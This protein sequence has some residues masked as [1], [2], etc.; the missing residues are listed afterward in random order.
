MPIRSTFKLFSPVTIPKRHL[1]Q[2]T[3]TLLLSPHAKPQPIVCT[4]SG[5]PDY[6]LIIPK[7]V[8]SALA[9]RDLGS[10]SAKVELVYHDGRHF[11]TAGV[12]NHGGV[13]V[14]ALDKDPATPRLTLPEGEVARMLDRD[15]ARDVEAT[16]F[17]CGELEGSG[18]AL[19]GGEGVADIMCAMK[20]ELLEAT[21]VGAET[22]KKALRD[23][24]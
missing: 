6:A 1:T 7:S 17:N 18:V 3:G 5:N 19:K 9:G 21:A 22:F 11:A 14:A 24:R 15:G 10:A 12:L 2:T 16:L 20:E 4:I 23:M 8:G 13:V